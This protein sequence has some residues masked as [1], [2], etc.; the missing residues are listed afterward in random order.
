MRPQ[1]LSA[2]GAGTQHCEQ[3]PRVGEGTAPP[4]LLPLET[5]EPLFFPGVA[6]IR[7]RETCV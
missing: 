4:V 5:T 7:V 2:S 6:V 3:S 1:L